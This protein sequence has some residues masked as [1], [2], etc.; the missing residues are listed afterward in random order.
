MS[1]FE[2]RKLIAV[3]EAAAWDAGAP[4]TWWPPAARQ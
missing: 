4:R 3:G 1:T 2:G